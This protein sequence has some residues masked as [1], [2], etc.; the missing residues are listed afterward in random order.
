MSMHKFVKTNQC[1]LLYGD[2]DFTTSFLKGIYESIK[3]KPI[4]LRQDSLQELDKRFSGVLKSGWLHVR[5]TASTGS[6]SFRKF[7]SRWCV[8]TE[9]AM[10]VCRDP[11]SLD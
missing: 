11:I 10:H 1:P 6:L 8:L 5:R 7:K 9:R 4:R 3:T 2:S